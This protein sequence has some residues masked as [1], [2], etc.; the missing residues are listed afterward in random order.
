MRGSVALVFRRRFGPRAAWQ[1][2]PRMASLGAHQCL[3]AHSRIAE[4]S[5]SQVGSFS[6]QRASD[7]IQTR[8]DEW[9]QRARRHEAQSFLHRDCCGQAMGA[10]ES[11][12]CG[13]RAT[14]SNAEL[15][16][17]GKRPMLPKVLEIL[18]GRKYLSER[19]E[20]PESTRLE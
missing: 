11:Y 10:S 3:G 4:S 13:Q 5:R 15:C 14:V 9:L 16:K 17:G 12:R 20:K 1:A 19:S 8:F 2:L 18:R 6:S 7:R